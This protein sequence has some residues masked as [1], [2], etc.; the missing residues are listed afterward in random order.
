MRMSDTEPKINFVLLKN[1]DEILTKIYQTNDENILC[2]K[3]PLII[4]RL[5]NQNGFDINLNK[6]IPYTDDI[7]IQINRNDIVTK[8]TIN[9]SLEEYY[10]SILNKID[11]NVNDNTQDKYILPTDS[12]TLH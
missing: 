11:T 4:K 12:I 3:E 9:E 2:F 8:S 7:L 5:E 10:D 6:W 1:G